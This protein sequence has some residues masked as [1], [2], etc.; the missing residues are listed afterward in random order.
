[1]T[2]TALLLP[3]PAR[4]AAEAPPAVRGVAQPVAGGE[5]VHGGRGCGSRLAHGG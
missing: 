1:M 3:G 5:R 4:G 2:F